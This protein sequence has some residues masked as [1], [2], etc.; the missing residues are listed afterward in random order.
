LKIAIKLNFWYKW[1]NF[2]GVIEAGAKI[3]GLAE[4]DLMNRNYLPQ[5][6]GQRRWLT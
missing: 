5:G 3:Q 2:S 4:N 6:A 1:G